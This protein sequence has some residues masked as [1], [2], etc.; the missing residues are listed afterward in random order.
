[1]SRQ[2]PTPDLSCPVP[3]G[4]VPRQ[5]H[6]HH[7]GLST[8]TYAPTVHTPARPP[9]PHP[10]TLASIHHSTPT[11]CTHIQTTA[12]LCCCAL[13]HTKRLDDRL[14]HALTCATNLEVLEGTLRLCAP[15]PAFGWLVGGCGLAHA[16]II[17]KE[18][19]IGKS[20]RSRRQCVVGWC[21]W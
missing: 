20:S 8:N 19:W 10:N 11:T 9:A 2:S 18:E 13:E 15:V 6:A 4:C 3:A 14:R 1:M 16:R 7:Q 21:W 17:A 12:H 5:Q